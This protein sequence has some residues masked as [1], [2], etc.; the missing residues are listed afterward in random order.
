MNCLAMCR[1][2]HLSQCVASTGALFDYHP[3]ICTAVWHL[4]RAFRICG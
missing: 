2:T 3:D 4:H 1:G